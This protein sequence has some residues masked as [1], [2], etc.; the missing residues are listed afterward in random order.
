MNT[1]FQ[2]V[3]TKE[4]SGPLTDKDPSPHPIMPDISITTA[5]ILNL[6]QNLDIHKASGPDQVS[7]RV[8]KETAE[9]AAPI[10][11]TIFT[12][13]MDTGNVPDDFRKANIT[14]IFKKGDRSQPSNYRP[15][16]LTC[17]V[18]NTLAAIS[19]REH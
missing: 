4:H 11:K 12:Y 16:S 1:R 7:A 3:F 2:L 15:T 10:L 13:S 8:L 5:G 18:S 14:P 19:Y 6:L 9:S 17:I